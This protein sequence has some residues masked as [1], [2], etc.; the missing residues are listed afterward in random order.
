MEQIELFWFEFKLTDQ[1]GL[2]YVVEVSH[3]VNLAFFPGNPALVFQ[4]VVMIGDLQVVQWKLKILM[5]FINILLFFC[6]LP[7]VLKLYK[8]QA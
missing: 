7:K 4:L 6:K 2:D 5:R 1:Q 8:Q 3:V